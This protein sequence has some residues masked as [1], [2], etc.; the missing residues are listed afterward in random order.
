[1]S[2]LSVHCLLVYITYAVEYFQRFCVFASVN[3]HPGACKWKV[4]QSRDI[5]I[6]GKRLAWRDLQQI[7]TRSR[8]EKGH[9]FH[10]FYIH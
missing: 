7:A 8:A 5:Q 1:M 6:F 2:S 10:S 4:F 9:I 3:V